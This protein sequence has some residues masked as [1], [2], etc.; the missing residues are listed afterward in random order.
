MAANY[1]LG[2]RHGRLQGGPKNATIFCTPHN[3]TNLT[4]VSHLVMV[5][6]LCTDDSK[7]F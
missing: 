6:G 1:G 5:M 3:F 7:D 2:H 4:M